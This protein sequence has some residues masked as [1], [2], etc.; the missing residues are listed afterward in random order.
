[1][2][3]FS[4]SGFSCP[5]GYGTYEPLQLCLLKSSSTYTFNAAKSWCQSQAAGGT[6]ASLVS[7]HDKAFNTWLMTFSPTTR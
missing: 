1:M 4:A 7:P 5:S 2:N 3:F 6:T